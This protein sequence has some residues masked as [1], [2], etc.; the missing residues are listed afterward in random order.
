MA[1]LLIAETAPSVTAGLVA[2]IHAF[3]F[4]EDL[5]ARHN[6]GHDVSVLGG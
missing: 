1:T 3:L 4:S 6:A 5:D 2:A